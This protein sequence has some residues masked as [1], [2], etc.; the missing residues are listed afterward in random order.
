MGSTAD[1]AQTAATHCWE[2]RMKFHVD[3][4][5]YRA[6]LTGNQGYFPDAIMKVRICHRES[7]SSGHNSSSHLSTINSNFQPIS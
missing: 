3:L 2:K 7:N 1:D 6:I 5:R 4:A